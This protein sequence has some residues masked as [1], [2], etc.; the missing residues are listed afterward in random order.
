MTFSSILHSLTTISK[1]SAHASTS[2]FKTYPKPTFT[3]TLWF[4]PPLSL[5]GLF[6]RILTTVFLLPLFATLPSLF[7]VSL[8]AAG[9][10]LVDLSQ[11]M[12]LSCSKPSRDFPSHAKD[13]QESLQCPFIGF[14]CPYYFSDLMPTTVLSPI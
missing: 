2:S 4:R 14:C 3:A 1:P 13:T 7:S 9:G 12:S 6:S 10:I 8:L 11:F 5:H